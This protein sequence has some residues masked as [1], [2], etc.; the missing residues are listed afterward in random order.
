MRDVGCACLYHSRLKKAASLNRVFQRK[1]ASTRPPSSQECAS[2]RRQAV[3]IP[4]WRPH[5]REILLACRHESPRPSCRLA[6]RSELK[7]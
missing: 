5:R 3:P 1:G 2:G 6:D 4:L 7:L